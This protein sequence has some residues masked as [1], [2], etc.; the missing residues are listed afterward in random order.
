MSTVTIFQ[1]CDCDINLTS[2]TS[3]SHVIVISQ[4][5]DDPNKTRISLLAH[6]NPGGGMPQWVRLLVK[7]PLLKKILSSEQFR[8]RQ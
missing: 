8:F 1:R 6:A 4:D 5:P 7:R 2:A 3:L